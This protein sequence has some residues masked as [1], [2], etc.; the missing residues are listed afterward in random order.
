VLLSGHLDDGSTGLLVVRTRGGLA[1]VQDPSAAR[2][3]EMP[4]RALEYAGADYVLPVSKIAPK[5]IELVNSR[6]VAMKKSRS[7]N[8]K[9]NRRSN[10]DNGASEG[11]IRIK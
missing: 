10:K 3:S 2:A 5:L 7:S 1:L 9:N 11:E 6:E 8:A 4:K